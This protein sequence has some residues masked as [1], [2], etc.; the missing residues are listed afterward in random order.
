MKNGLN[1]EDI[2]IATLD[3]KVA[4]I[5][6]FN[7]WFGVSITNA[8]GVELL[9]QNGDKFFSDLTKD[10]NEL[11]PEVKAMFEGLFTY[12]KKSNDAKLPMFD[13]TAVYGFIDDL[14][15]TGKEG[16]V[17]VIYPWELNTLTDIAGS[18]FDVMGLNKAKFAGKELKHWKSGWALVIN[19][20]NEEDK[21]K[22][23]LSEA[24]IA[25]LLNPQFAADFYKYTSKIMPN[26]T[27]EE[28]EKLELPELDKKAIL[29]VLDS[30][31]NATIRPLFKE[32]G[33]V[34][35]TWQSALISWESKKPATA[36]DA[37]KEV[38]ASFKALLTNLG[39]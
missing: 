16:S 1:L 12:W 14:F 8:F 26:V 39:Q 32:W 11:T 18:D 5:P 4:S 38:Q 7:A 30:Y 22:L 15:K 20:R 2:D 37:Y 19:A 21:D 27:K 33:Q 23:A 35:D 3:P 31:D 13:I 28:Y 34:W 9:G 36:E 24:I 17:R 6:V 25:E 10:W 29:S